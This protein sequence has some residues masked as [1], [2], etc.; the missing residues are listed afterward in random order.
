LI[1]R[2]LLPYEPPMIEIPAMFTAFL[3][4]ALSS[5]SSPAVEPKQVREADA[6]ECRL[7]V[8]TYQGFA[9]AIE[10]EEALAKQRGWKKIP[11]ANPLFLEFELPE[12]ISVAG[13]YS[14]RRIAFTADAI[15]AV[16]DLPDP[17]VIAGKEQIANTMDSEPMIAALVAT[18]K[19]SRDEAERMIPFRKFLGERIVQ[20]STE[21]APDKDGF[22][23]HFVV[24][25][26]ISNV[27]T[28]PGK[29]FYGCA[30]RMELIDSAGAPL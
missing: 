28:H 10:G 4:S 23:G 15:L 14:T 18:G 9:F 7:D 12:P 5:A 24:A 2:A 16:L 19:V 8:P 29:T 11:S 20:E 25:R 21:K 30:Y 6:I 26:T 13:T 22:G 27:R 17:A 3:I 1:Q